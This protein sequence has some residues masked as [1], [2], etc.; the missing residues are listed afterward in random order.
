[1]NLNNTPKP[2]DDTATVDQSNP[3]TQ[4]LGK[5]QYLANTKQLNIAH[6]VHKLASYTA[7]P[8]LDHHFALKRI[9]RI[10][11]VQLHMA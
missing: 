4:L 9:L 6:A 8:T 1:M 11:K 7:N 2:N 10:W 3:Y 5:L